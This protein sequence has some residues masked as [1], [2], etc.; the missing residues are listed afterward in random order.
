MKNRLATALVIVALFIGLMIAA[1]LALLVLRRAGGA[2]FANTPSVVVQIQS[3]SELVTVKYVIEK[4]IFAETPATNLIDRLRGSDKIILLGHGIVKAGVDLSQVKPADVEVN[5]TRI[6]VALPP[7][8]VT[9]GYLDENA[10]QVLDRQA[11][12]ILRPFNQKLEQQARQEA[13]NEIVRSA[14]QSGIEREA[15]QRA[16]EQLTRFLQSLGYTEVDIHTRTN[17]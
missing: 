3:L 16:V 2:R 6:R 4:V 12:F 11:G 1:L 10:T 14:R 13:R 15:N 5:G 8:I 7:S 17:K 9:D